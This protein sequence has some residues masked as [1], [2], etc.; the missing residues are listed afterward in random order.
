MPYYELLA[1]ASART[2]RAGLVDLTTRTAAAF[3][4]GGA[5]LTRL[6]TLPPAGAPA[7]APAG[8]R[9]LAYRIRRNQVNHHYAYYL[10]FCGAF[11]R[12][13]WQ[14]VLG[15]GGGVVWTGGGGP[16]LCRRGNVVRA[17]HCGM[18]RSTRLCVGGA[19]SAG[20]R[21]CAYCWAVAFVG[22]RVVWIER[23]RGGW[24][25]RACGRPCGR[26]RLDAR[27]DTSAPTHSLAVLHD[28]PRTAFA[29]PVT[30]AEVSRRLRND[31][32]V[33]RHLAVKLPLAVRFCGGDGLRERRRGE[34]VGGSMRVT[35]VRGL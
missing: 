29:S 14:E 16:D 24:A 31:D 23:E 4:D 2:T 9:R 26:D 34:R 25:R 19:S 13:E 21:C 12:G 6:A 11:W 32:A 15:C 5:T 33:I 22:R 35:S 7:G 10:Q 1:L 3:L 20:A 30:L 17:M 8:P 27:A 18:Q 28:S